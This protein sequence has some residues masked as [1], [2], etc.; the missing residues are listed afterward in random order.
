MRPAVRYCLRWS[1]PIVEDRFNVT[2]AGSDRLH[3]EGGNNLRGKKRARVEIKLGFGQ[4]VNEITKN[5][6]EVS[7]DG[8]NMA[9]P[10]KVEADSLQIRWEIWPFTLKGW[11]EIGVQTSELAVGSC[12]TG[13]GGSS[14]RDRASQGIGR[15]CRGHG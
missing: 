7:D 11:L 2:R 6:R 4:R 12:G 3:A 9:R 10:L 15:C 13:D 14:R 1:C 5:V 8:K